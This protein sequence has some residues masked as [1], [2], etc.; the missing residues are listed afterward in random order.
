MVLVPWYWRRPP[1]MKHF[2]VATPLKPLLI[3]K[4]DGKSN[5]FAVL[6]SPSRSIFA[7]WP[8]RFTA[9]AWDSANSGT[10]GMKPRWPRRGGVLEP[11]P[12]PTVALRECCHDH[13][14][15]KSLVGLSA[16][17][18]L[19]SAGN[20]KMKGS[21]TWMWTGSE[22]ATVWHVIAFVPVALAA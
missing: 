15:A 9:K 19:W 20:R 11:G 13:D 17:S 6:L 5:C 21:R 7:T 10:P 14:S 22:S 4:A 12:A 16:L 1:L 3:Q 18:A 2:S 8:K